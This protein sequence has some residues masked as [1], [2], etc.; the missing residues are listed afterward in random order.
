M[1]VR[2]LNARVR[3]LNVKSVD[4]DRA[5]SVLVEAMYFGIDRA[6]SR[7]G[8]NKRTVK[9]YKIRLHTDNELAQKF[10]QKKL[11][12]EG[13]WAADIP[14]AI[15]SATQFLLNAFQE[16]EPTAENIHAVAGAMKLLAEVGFTKE[17]IDA[18]LGTSDRQNDEENNTMASP[19]TITATAEAIVDT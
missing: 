1:A 8:V 5:A 7:W 19:R 9:N 4:Y 10:E 11:K 6:A 18:R 15:R 14:A 3:G 13:E 2:T 16:L 12:F 17:I